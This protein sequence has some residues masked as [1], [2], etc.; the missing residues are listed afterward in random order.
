MAQESEVASLIAYLA[1][2]LAAAVNGAA[3]R[4]E[5]GILRALF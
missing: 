4:C 2:P 1:S 5:G 3:I